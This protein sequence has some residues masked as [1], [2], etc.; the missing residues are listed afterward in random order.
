V[1]QHR[2]VPGGKVSIPTRQPLL[3]AALAFATGIFLGSYLSR[4]A[5][6]WL[7]AGIFFTFSGLYFLRRRT[8]AALALGLSALIA[9]GA[10]TIQVRPP[11]SIGD[12]NILQF[13]D[14]REVILTAHI[15]KEGIAHTEAFGNSR[16]SL[17]VET[18]QIESNGS[19]FPVRSGIRI[20]FYSKEDQDEDNKDTTSVSFQYGARL[21]FPA[22]LFAPHNF[23]NP[24]AF[25]YRAYLADNGIAALGSAK[26]SNVEFVA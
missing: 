2:N 19:V 23:G 4:P 22:K 15:I 20:S 25:D 14:S 13:T 18:E 1:K 8:W 24:G 17:D 21:R 5:I 16:R 26:V 3:W 9:A 10:F 11:A 7:T 12:T 6:W